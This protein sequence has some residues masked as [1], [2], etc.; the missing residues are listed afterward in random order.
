MNYQNLFNNIEIV[1]VIESIIIHIMPDINTLRK[2]NYSI[3]I[4]LLLYY[5]QNY[6][7]YLSVDNLKEKIKEEYPDIDF[8]N[9]RINCYYSSY[10]QLNGKQTIFNHLGPSSIS[11]TIFNDLEHKPK[12][13]IEKKYYNLNK[14]NLFTNKERF[15]SKVE[16]RKLSTIHKLLILKYS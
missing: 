16:N 8:F 5:N 4:P 13:I 10:Y 3:S 12:D 7:K 1:S 14:P 6:E 9:S 2:I 15:F 11:K